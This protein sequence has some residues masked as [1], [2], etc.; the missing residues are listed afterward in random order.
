M[1]SDIGISIESRPFECEVHGSVEETRAILRKGPTSWSGC[2]ACNESR[3]AEQEQAEAEATE[4]KRVEKAVKD[5]IGYAA[6]PPRFANKNF[7]SYVAKTDEQK[8]H[9]ERCKSYVEK[10]DEHFKS[11]AGLLMMGSPGTGKTHLAVATL[12]AVIAE[13]RTRG[14][15]TTAARM[16]RRIKSTYDRDSEETESQVIDIY[17]QIGLLV[18]DE[19]GLGFGSDTEMNY[20]FDVINYRYEQCLPTIIIS[21]RQPDELSKW[22]GDRVVDRLRECC[23]AMKFDWKSERRD[24]GRASA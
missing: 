6:I 3:R 24:I 21:N 12:H 1:I 19:I 20:L 9:L 13:K 10:F 22:L 14:L 11:G 17:S 5:A 7:D 2:Q 4:R 8:R 16:F 15:Y 23:K 18:L